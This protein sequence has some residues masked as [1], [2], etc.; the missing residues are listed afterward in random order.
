M[1]KNDYIC[2]ENYMLSCM[3]DSA[4]DREHV[5]R[6]LYGALK[7]GKDEPGVDW[8]VLVCACLLHD[9]GRQEQ[10]RDASLD[11]ASVGAEKAY[12]FL[13]K[14]GYGETFAARVRGCIFTHRF[15]SE[16]PPESPEAKLLFDADKLDVCGALGMARTLLYNGEEGEPLYSLLPD[17][18]VSPGEG[19]KEPSFFQEYKKKLEGIYGRFFTE[20]GKA[21]AGERRQAAVN[22][23][24]ALL[25]ESSSL[26]DAGRAGLRALFGEEIALVRLQDRPELREPLARWFHKK[27][28]VPLEAY[29][30]SMD[31]CLSARSA[32]PQWYAALDGG[33]IAGG[34]GVIEND[35]HDRKDLTPNVCAV[36]VEEAYRCRGI[37][38][39]L[40]RFVCRDMKERGVGTLYL[41]TDH[42]SFYERYGWE[43]FCMAQGD[44]EEGPSRMYRHTEP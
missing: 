11:H 16:H 20:K 44:G 14:H 4:H 31:E 33:T 8:N 39:Q 26:Y 18:R 37:A 17:G 9:I 5:Y 10:F 36:Y 24:E 12:R 2:W 21:L 28:G 15:R 34:L 38:G 43:F 22:F 25:R 32:V 40:L 3:Q 19:D 41:L 13:T 30:E 29:L 23:Y 42:T 1:T 35:F 27:W 7:L 6:V